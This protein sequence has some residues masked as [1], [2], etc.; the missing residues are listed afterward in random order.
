VAQ[1]A[2]TDIDKETI[3]EAHKI[4]FD[5]Y[6]KADAGDYSLDFENLS[7]YVDDRLEIFNSSSHH[8]GTTRIS[9]NPEEGVVDTD[10]KVHGMKNLYVAGSS[11]FPTGGHANPTLTIV[12][13]A[14]RLAGFL[15][16]KWTIP[17]GSSQ[18]PAYYLQQH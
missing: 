12:A 15:K 6:T 4:F 2:F 1:I 10:C 16:K 17:Q 3:I 18:Y 14:V 7:T 11:V 5:R 9:E 13:L 8:L